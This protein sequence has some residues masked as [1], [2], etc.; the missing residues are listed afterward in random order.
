ME[1]HGY[2]SEGMTSLPG[3]SYV[4]VEEENDAKVELNW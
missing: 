1:N 2:Q 4:S 3:K